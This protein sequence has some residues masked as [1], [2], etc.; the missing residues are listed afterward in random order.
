MAQSAFFPPNRWE[1]FAM[2][3]K[4]LYALFHRQPFQPLRVVMKDGRSFEARF[5]RLAIV[6]FQHLYLGIPIPGDPDP[7]IP[8]SDPIECLPLMDIDRVESISVTYTT[9]LSS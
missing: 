6:G 7:V 1:T 9:I 8:I 4:E 2:Q 3:E 5:P